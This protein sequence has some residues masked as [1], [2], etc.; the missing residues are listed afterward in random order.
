MPARA[1]H[2]GRALRS[3]ASSPTCHARPRAWSAA[4]RT[5]N[6]CGAKR[7]SRASRGSRGA[8]ST[9][10]GLASRGGKLLYATCSIFSDENESGIAGFTARH[11]DALRETLTFAPEID[12]EGGQL[13]PSLPGACHNQDGFYYARLRKA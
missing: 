13:L 6:G 7:T 10:C 2:G 1:Q 4:I 8:C 3:I 12:C 11:P 9:R 5:A